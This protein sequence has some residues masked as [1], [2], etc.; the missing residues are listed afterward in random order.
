MSAFLCSIVFLSC[1]LYYHAHVGHV[2]YAG[3]W[4]AVY[5]PILLTHTVL[6]VLVV[7]MILRTLFLA[8]KERFEEHRAAARWA[9]PIWLYVSVTG[10]IVYEMLY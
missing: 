2:K 7:P 9:F 3:A 4:G 5:Y 6:A 10:V 8:V 1:Y